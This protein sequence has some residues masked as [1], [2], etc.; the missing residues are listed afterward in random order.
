MIK[1]LRF[2]SDMNRKI[3]ALAIPSIIANVTTPLLG[4]VDTAIVGHMGSAVFIA[5]IA[6]G[7][8]VFNL[9]YWCF[10]FLRMGSSGMTAQAF[11][12]GDAA[13]QG[14]VLYRS[15]AVS[16]AAGVAMIALSRPLSAGVLCFMEADGPTAELAST[17]IAVAVWGA[18]AVLGVYSL[19]GWFLGMQNS[20][21]PM[22][23]SI[24]V[25]LMNIAV[26][27]LLVYRLEWGIEGVACG[28]M[29]AQWGG[30]LLGCVILM[31]RYRPE[32]PGWS[33]LMKW[34]GLRRF[35][36]INLDIFLR[37]VCIV[38]VTLWFTRSGS[39]QGTL[40]LA[41]NALLMQFFMLFSY[42]MDG[43]AFAGEALSG[44]AVGASDGDGLRR[45]VVSLMGWGAALAALFA[46][47]Y[48][49]G[50]EWLLGVLSSQDDVVE[51]AAGYLPWAVSM[52]LAGFAAFTLDGVF[53]GATRTR[54]MLRSM[55]V[56][57]AVFFAVEYLL[58]PCLGN[59]ALWLAFELYLLSRGVAQSL[60]ARG[61]L[62][63]N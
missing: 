37:T 13:G 47:A 56:A 9:L 25:N 3:L 41:V 52:P 23:I 36:S 16:A 43:F 46:V 58:F 38:A 7:G 57:A 55:V 44:R 62:L 34:G 11:G 21:A 60:L 17:Y 45:C 54:D 32:F 28:T 4:L 31:R 2:I 48:G 63:H 30:F 19:S 49:F 39:S 12:A 29:A 59:H 14:L 27:L 51:M 24:F 10:A 5:A 22:W 35:F 33:N 6:L 50:G 18:P 53:I 8:S 40:V 26:S 20:R 1:R 42:V 15:L 61:V